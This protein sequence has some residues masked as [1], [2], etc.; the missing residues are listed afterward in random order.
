MKN[1]GIN[2]FFHRMQSVKTN[3]YSK[4]L[5]FDLSGEVYTVCAKV[6]EYCLKLIKIE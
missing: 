1:G 4:K 3:G 6:S 5:A 2:A